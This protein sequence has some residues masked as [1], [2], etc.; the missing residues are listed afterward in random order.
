MPSCSTRIKVGNETYPLLTWTSDM[1]CWSWS[2]PAMESCPLAQAKSENDICTSCYAMINRYGMPNVLN[3]QY[4][5]FTWTK[6]LLKEDSDYF[7]KFMT[8]AIQKHV[9]NERFRAHDSGDLFSPKYIDTW[10]LIC[11]QLPKIKFWFPTRSWRAKS[12]RWQKSLRSLCSLGNVTVRPSA[13]QY[14]DLPPVLDG[15]SKGTTVYLNTNDVHR[16]VSLCP[17]TT[18]GGSCESNNC[19]TCWQNVKRVGYLV[20]GRGGKHKPSPF[21][22]HEQTRRDDLANKFTKRTVGI[23]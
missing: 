1:A 13:L 4:A 18:N 16:Y 20:H 8:E 23:V 10:E 14:N 21:S 15:Y 7:V 11:K 22:K 9:K 6:F 12:K 19:F 5:R 3:A 17:K 2:L